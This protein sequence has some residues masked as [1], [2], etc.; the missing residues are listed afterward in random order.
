MR[1]YYILLVC[2]LAVV[3]CGHEQTTSEA[4]AIDTLPM[5][6]SQLRQQSRLYT[7]EVQMHKVVSYADEKTVKLPFVD[8]INVPFT[9]RKG[10]IPISATVK[11]YV[12]LSEIGEDNVRRSGDGIEVVLPDPVIVMTATAIDH[13]QIKKEEGWLADNFDDAKMAQ[14]QQQG[15]KEMV[16]DLARLDITEQARVNAAHQLTPLIARLGFAEDQITITFRK[17]FTVGDLQKMISER[18]KE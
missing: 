15:R 8:K 7:A 18:M 2:A 9:Q 3:S 12:D 4:P 10:A 17:R 11:A 6:V 16:K 1:I 14:I 13:K 5:L